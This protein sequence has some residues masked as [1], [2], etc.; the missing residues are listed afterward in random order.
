MP[1]KTTKKPTT[2]K[3][4]KAVVTKNSVLPYKIGSDPEFLMFYGSRGLDASDIISNFFRNSTEVRSADSGYKIEN[5]GVFGWDGASSTGELRPVATDNIEVMVKN[6]GTMLSKISEKMPFVDLTTLSIGSPIGGHIHLDDFLHHLDGNR[7]NGIEVNNQREK[8]RVVRL[9]ATYLMP[10]AASDHRVSAINRLNSNNYG[11]LYDI[12]FEKKGPAITAEVRGLT[13]EWMTTPKIAYATFA[14]LATVWHELKT[15]SLELSKDTNILR[16]EEHINQMHKMLLS[17]Y[18]MIEETFCKH[19]HKQVKTFALYKQFQEEIDFIC[20]PSLVMKEK[21]RVGWNINNGWSLN[22][23]TVKPTKSVLL[24][25]KAVA[26][27]MKTND[28]PDVERHFAIPY[29]DDYNVAKFSTAISERIASVNWQLKNDYFL[30]GMMKGVEGYGVMNSAKEF[31]AIPHNRAH[32]ATN[33]TFERM[34]SR[35][36]N[37]NIFRGARIDPKNGSIREPMKNLIIIGIP[38]KERSVDDT[39][40]LIEIIWKIENKKLTP[41][42]INQFVA[43]PEVV[44]KEEPSSLSQCIANDEETNLNDYDVSTITRELQINETN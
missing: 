37:R 20:N 40:S 22:T 44:G 35:A 39:R 1:T 23:K 32:H 43:V 38:Y 3:S 30:F 15:R 26:Q 36:H 19:I 33:E 13:A 31:F 2:T 34:L 24:G 29:N 18:K 27:V 8:T 10:V 16:T 6:I 11:K 4:K 12:R 21:E 41:Q 14:Y 17:D 42:S 25:K 5:V 7:S 9:M 28:I